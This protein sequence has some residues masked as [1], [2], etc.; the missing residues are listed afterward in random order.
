VTEKDQG[1]ETFDGHLGHAFNGRTV[2]QFVISAQES[3]VNGF[4]QKLGSRFIGS[5]RSKSDIS[6]FKKKLFELGSLS[7]LIDD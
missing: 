3:S 1:Q 6:Y 5:F 2:P 4:L 7:V